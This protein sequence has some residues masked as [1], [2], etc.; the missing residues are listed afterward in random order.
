ML[1]S[2]QRKIKSENP[3][4]KR[5]IIFVICLL[6][7]VYAAVAVLL[8]ERPTTSDRDPVANQ[9]VV[10]FYSGVG[11]KG[12]AMATRTFTVGLEYGDLGTAARTGFVF[13]HWVDVNGNRVNNN[14]T[15]PNRNHDLIAIWRQEITV[16]FYSGIGG[17]GSA[18]RTRTFIVGLP[19]GD[20]GSATR[21]GEFTFSHWV[22]VDGKTVNNDDEVPAHNHDLI[23]I[24]K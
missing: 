11:G 8:I 24:W 18:M 2:A 9:I 15:V 14:M 16:T 5:A 10:T 13:S 7:I 20:L 4:M 17:K 1:N 22:N 12:N 6:V 23:A 3:K 19:Y 21:S